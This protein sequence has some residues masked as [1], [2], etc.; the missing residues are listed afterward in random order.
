LELGTTNALAKLLIQK[1]IIREPEFLDKLSAARA[2][3]QAIL[4]QKGGTH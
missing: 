4:K 2:T 3:Y 1:V